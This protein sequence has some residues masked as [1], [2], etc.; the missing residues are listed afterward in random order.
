VTIWDTL[1]PDRR[2][3]VLQRAEQLIREERARRSAPDQSQNAAAAG[4]S[5][6]IAKIVLVFLE[7]ARRLLQ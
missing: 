7:K 1:P 2:E 4:G 3:A 5:F 6:S